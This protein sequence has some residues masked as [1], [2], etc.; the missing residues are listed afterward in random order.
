[1]ET[2]ID[3]NFN[4]LENCFIVVL[5]D[6]YLIYK[7]NPLRLLYSRNHKFKNIKY[8][9][10]YYETNVIIFILEN[11]ENHRLIMWDDSKQEIMAEIILITKIRKILLRRNYLIIVTF[12]V[13]YIYKLTNN[14]LKFFR[15]F[16]TLNNIGICDISKIG[17]FII[18]FPFKKKGYIKIVN[19]NE[20][21]SNIIKAHESSINY[22]C[23]RKYIASVSTK[24]TI[25]RIFDLN[26]KFLNEFRRGI[27]KSFIYWLN[28]NV[29]SDV[30][31]CQSKKGTIH[32]FKTTT[33]PYLLNFLFSNRSY[34]QFHFINIKTISKIEDNI[35]Y[36]ISDLGYF[37]KINIEKNDFVNVKRKKLFKIEKI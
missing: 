25:I 11:K 12:E 33:E 30:L 31:I 35:L 9:Q 18:A 8:V 7:L 13:I 21:T 3:F 5:E 36:V 15:K 27:E 37:Y 16:E 22:I 20:N 6:R 29:N 26:G 10:M 14:D 24:G 28:F 4:Q 23:I 17:D 19:I 2:I 1:M 32:L 34:A